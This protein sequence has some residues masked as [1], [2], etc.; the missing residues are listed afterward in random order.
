MSGCPPGQTNV[1]ATLQ[2]SSVAQ[3]GS[4][5]E[6]T[7][8]R[9]GCHYFSLVCIF[10][11][12]PYSTLLFPYTVLLNGPQLPGPS[13]VVDFQ[14]P[15]VFSVVSQVLCSR[16]SSCL[17]RK[18]SLPDDSFQVSCRPCLIRGATGHLLFTQPRAFWL[19]AYCLG[20]STHWT[21][22][23]FIFRNQMVYCRTNYQIHAPCPSWLEVGK[24]HPNFSVQYFK[25]SS[26][27][28][29]VVRIMIP[30][31]KL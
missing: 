5:V 15:S 16:E 26:E 12:Y 14:S 31:C 20:A 21:F 18:T 8:L 28:I 27:E 10:S 17:C 2:D 4:H 29:T 6:S 22:L 9:C 30:T 11:I 1:S 7:W 3:Q 19:S 23:S 13:Q 24:G 25:D